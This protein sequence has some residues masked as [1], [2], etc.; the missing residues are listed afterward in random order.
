MTHVNNLPENAKKFPFWV[1]RMV[2]DEFWFWG[3]CKTSAE[4][5]KIAEQINGIVIYNIECQ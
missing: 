3:A 5:F 1:T 4:A 2:K